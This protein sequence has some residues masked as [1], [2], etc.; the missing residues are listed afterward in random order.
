MSQSRNP[1]RRHAALGAAVLLTLALS[2]CSNDEPSDAADAGSTPSASSTT[3]TST[4]Q[5]PGDGGSPSADPNSPF[6]VAASAVAERSRDQVTQ[7]HAMG[8]A[9]TGAG[10]LPKDQ[11][12][13]LA[14]AIDTALADQIA[15]CTMMPPPA[16]SPAAKLVGALRDY[17]ELSQDLAAWSPGGQALAGSWFSRLETTDGAWK[18][19]LRQLGRLTDEDLLADLAPLLLPS[20]A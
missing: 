18:A 9:T 14:E 16:G 11:I 5:P 3:A 12:P 20:S 17:R 6:V 10:Q 1:V 15:A 19:A 2:A 8:L 13:Q 4:G 7:L